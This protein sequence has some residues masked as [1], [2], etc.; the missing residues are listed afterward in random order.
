MPS[1]RRTTTASKK[2]GFSALPGPRSASIAKQALHPTSVATETAVH[3]A[4]ALL[5]S[6]GSELPP[7]ALAA[8]RRSSRRRRPR[9]AAAV[10]GS[11]PQELARARLAATNP[12]GRPVAA[13]PSSLRSGG[14]GANDDAEDDLCKAF[15]CSRLMAHEVRSAKKI[16]ATQFTGSHLA[17]L[18]IGHSNWNFCISRLHSTVRRGLSRR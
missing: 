8:A 7:A 17:S 9:T 3:V 2:V 18:V 10:T 11:T 5:S 4:A 14:G 6:D 13:L 16:N 15:G 1:R 12:L